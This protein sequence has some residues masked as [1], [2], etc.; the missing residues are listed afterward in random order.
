MLA[1]TGDLDA[2]DASLHELRM[3]TFT[4]DL[5]NKQRVISALKAAWER[6]IEAA[7]LYRLLAEQ[8][9]EERRR[10]IFIKLAEAEE[11]HAREFADRILALGGIPPRDSTEPTA[12]QRL[13]V[14]SLG[15]DAMLRRL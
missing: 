3:R 12:K 2:R 11:G 4:E 6:E 15:T 7:Q 13:L 10:K 8:Q 1:P 9:E 5:V 14:R